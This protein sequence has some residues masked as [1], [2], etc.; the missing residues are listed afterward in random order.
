MILRQLLDV[1]DPTTGKGKRDRAIIAVLRHTG[2][3]VGELSALKLADVEISDR[4][5]HLTVRSGKGGKYRVVPLNV[6]V[7]RAIADYK[8]VRPRVL[9]EHLFIGQRGAGLSPAA[10]HYLVTKYARLAGLDGVSPHTLRHSMAKQALDAGTDLVTVATI[11]GHT[12]L[13]T[14]AIY[15]RPSA[16]DLERAVEKL[17]TG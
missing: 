8:E 2:I 10:I 7:R 4:K 1:P 14:T 9:N 12:R 6:D 11:L 15:T 17:E 13:E 5:G 3:R 16:R